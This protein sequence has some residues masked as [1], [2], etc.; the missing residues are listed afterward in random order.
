[1]A[2]LRDIGLAIIVLILAFL[3]RLYVLVVLLVFGTIAYCLIV[4][5]FLTIYSYL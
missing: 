2:L 4:G 1:M 5:I 3:S